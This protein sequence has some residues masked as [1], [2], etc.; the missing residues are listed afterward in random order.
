V[1]DMG[2]GE[3]QV[4]ERIS[5]TIVEHL[6]PRRIVLFGS[7]ARGTITP[8]SDYDIMVEME[9]DLPD[10]E[11]EDA[12]YDLFREY[13]S[14]H[15]SECDWSMDVHVYTP[16][17]V[18]RWKD[19]VGFIVYDIV[20]EGRVLYCRPDVAD[21]DFWGGDAVSSATR[22]RE[23]PSDAPMSLAVWI[24]RAREDFAAM[25]AVANLD[26]PVLGPVCFHAHQGAE[27]LLKACLVA[28]WVRPPRTHNLDKLLAACRRAGV[29]LRGL[30]GSCKR[31]QEL[32]PRSRYP[33]E[34]EPT[35]SDAKTAI[36]A[37]TAVHDAVL[38]M[39]ERARQP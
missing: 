36:A 17:E 3:D 18:R 21:G 20:R 7:R 35:M 2:V 1:I 37:A 19:D 10:G 28:R 33:K 9:T 38:P 30:R 31:L 24:R 32:Y 23:R 4:L 11:R 25:E 6:R 13:D 15:D 26:P 29:D 12:V 14:E 27:K 22:V 39:L 16:E 34:P 5:R 8:D